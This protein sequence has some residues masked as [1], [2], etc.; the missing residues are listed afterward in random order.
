MSAIAKLFGR[1]PFNLLQRHMEQASKCVSKMSEALD[2]FEEGKFDRL[3]TFAEEVSALEHQADQIRDDIRN[4]LLRRFFMPVDRE[5]V[6]RILSQQDSLADIAEDVCVLLTMKPLTIP[7]EL[8]DPFQRYR[9]LSVK[10][11]ELASCIIAE[12][13]EL[14]ESGF[15]GAEAEKI[16]ALTHDVAFTEHQADVVAHELV[17]G[18]YARDSEM[19]PGEF[20]LW[21]RLTRTLDGLSNTAENL[22]D[23]ITMVL[24]LK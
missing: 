19:T 18:I 6:L 24:S 14:L 10:S 20:F 21:M 9:A 8:K 7:E 1:S 15:G 2:A 5:H 11:V 3:P 23:S 16:R 4:H 22:A 17:R 13:D 12:L